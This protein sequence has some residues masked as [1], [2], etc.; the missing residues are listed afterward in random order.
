MPT[1][2]SVKVYVENGYYHIYNR[3][4]EKRDIFLDKQ[5]NAV[6]LRY[7]KEYLLPFDHP[8]LKELQ[9][10]NP[11]RR[12]INC[13]KDIK[14][15][16]YCLMPNHFHL[17]VKQKTKDG[18]KSFMKALSTNYVM[19][20]NHKYEREGRLFQGV[21][22]AALISTEPYYL[23]ITRYIHQNPS[24]LLTKNQALHEYPYSSYLY[25]LSGKGP[26]WLDIKEILKMFRSSRRLFPKDILSYQGFVEDY[27]IDEKETL[28]ELTLD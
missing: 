21:Y 17:F 24:E 12:P 13:Y 3:G 26:S 22:R 11:R 18:L 4:V 27:K 7:L 2:N 6:F 28:G 8:D 15:L 14:L 25:Y 23:H 10:K 1:K 9:T 16:S 20:F 19:Y 5:D